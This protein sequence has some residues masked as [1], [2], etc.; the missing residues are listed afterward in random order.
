MGSSSNEPCSM[1]EIE[2]EVGNRSETAKWVLSSPKPPS[3][4]RELVDSFK[5][6]V[7]KERNKPNRFIYLLQCL[8]PILTWGRVYDKGKFRSDIMSGLTLASLSIPQVKSNYQI[9]ELEFVIS[10]NHL[11]TC[12]N[13][14]QSIGYAGL[15]RLDPQYG[16]CKWIL[17]KLLSFE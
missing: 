14:L 1:E 17:P 4:W 13:L 15:A 9:W 11:I 3:P 10:L 5:E 12:M 7:T 8:F 6:T 2:M 16:L